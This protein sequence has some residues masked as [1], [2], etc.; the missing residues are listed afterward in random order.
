ML[1]NLLTGVT[2]VA[3]GVFVVYLILVA[4]RGYQVGGTREAGKELISG[5]V[6]AILVILILLSLFSAS[7]V[8]IE[9]QEVG[10]VVSLFSRDGYREQPMRSGLHFIVPLA[11]RVV[12]YPI[13]WQ[14]Y[15]MSTEPLEGSKVGDDSI[16][17]RT[18]DGQLVYLDSSVIYRIDANEV[19]R[20]HIDFQ[21]RYVDDFIRPLIRGIVR[22]EVSQFTADEVNS[23]KR[24]NLEQNLDE[25]LRDA[26]S[27]KGL[28][29]D[30]FLLRNIAFSPEYTK[31][32]EAKQV[33]EQ[34]RTQ[35]EY[36]AEQMRQL[37]QGTRDKT[38]IEAQGEATATVLKG[39]ADA[40]VILLKAQSQAE[41]LRLI[42]EILSENRD[43]I[44]YEYVDK[45]GPGVQVMLVPNDNPYLLPLPEML[46][47][48]SPETTPTPIPGETSSSIGN[49]PEFENVSTAT[50][51]PT[52]TP[53]PIGTP[54]AP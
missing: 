16:A 53:T 40:R 15:T 13:F 25:Q 27:E 7:L 37:A 4:L 43:L 49:L 41:A 2:L 52:F 39:E 32:I 34:A 24:K 10:V 11:E 1:D 23:S 29:L 5:R 33:A 17:S 50:P 28:I 18:S 21:N 9:P 22:T 36:E 12:H 45:L 19:V 38:E 14:T 54:A 35:R 31:A 3:W 6:L 20:L 46:G 8:F 30:R 48:T 26:F 44:T 51:T 47:P 42:N